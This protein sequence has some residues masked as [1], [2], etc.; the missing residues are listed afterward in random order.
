MHAAFARLPFDKGGV[1][2][3]CCRA[4]LRLRA[5][6]CIVEQAWQLVAKEEKQPPAGSKISTGRW[7]KEVKS[8]R[9]VPSKS[10]RQSSAAHL[11]RFD[12]QPLRQRWHILE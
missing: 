3:Y 1:L 10:T 6:F 11:R 9:V 12:M 4:Q 2:K 8:S 5:L 7:S